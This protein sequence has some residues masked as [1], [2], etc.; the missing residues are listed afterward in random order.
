[1]INGYVNTVFIDTM[2]NNINCNE[3]TRCGL[4][5]EFGEI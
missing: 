3:Y 5:D 2:Y 4:N 1:M